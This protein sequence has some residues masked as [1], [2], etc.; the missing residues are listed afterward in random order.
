MKLIT[1]HHLTTMKL[2]I[3]HHAAGREEPLNILSS[4][5]C[6]R[7]ESTTMKVWR[8]LK[9]DL[10]RHLGVLEKEVPSL[11]LVS[12]AL[13]KNTDRSSLYTHSSTEDTTEPQVCEEKTG[14][15]AEAVSSGGRAGRD[16]TVRS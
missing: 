9:P 5:R 13:L 12:R 2:I 1:V 4:I 14:F 8:L 7:E 16:Q 11:H 6:T 3:I 10:R 15:E